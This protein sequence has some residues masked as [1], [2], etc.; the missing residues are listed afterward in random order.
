MTTTT[1][2]V[3]KLWSLCNALRDDGISYLQYTT[4]LTYLLFLK[5][6]EETG[7]ETRLPEGYRWADLV[8]KEG[9]DQLKFYRELLLKLGSEDS[10]LLVQEIYANAQTALKQPRILTNSDLAPV[11]LG[12]ARL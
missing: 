10:D 2:I 5:M 6:A 7:T 4:E 12:R 9:I 3:Q 1:D 8:A 11:S